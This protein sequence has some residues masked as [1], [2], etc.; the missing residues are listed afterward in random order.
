MSP[1]AAFGTASALS[2][3]LLI[4]LPP[5][6]PLPSPSLDSDSTSLL[7]STEIAL[8]LLG[9]PLDADHLPTL[10]CPDLVHVK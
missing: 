1:S 2:Y 5:S 9:D 8:E 7:L 6:S 10:Q 3:K 4:I